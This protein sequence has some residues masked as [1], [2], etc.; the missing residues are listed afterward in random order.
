MLFLTTMPLWLSGLLLIVPT[1]ALAMAGPYVVR[2][3]VEL[4]RLRT[5]NEIAGF[6]YAGSTSRKEP[7]S[8]RRSPPI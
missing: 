1:T 4:S 5:N 6:K 8:A 7:R 3:Y 2:R